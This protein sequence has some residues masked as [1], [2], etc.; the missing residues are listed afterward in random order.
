MSSP[1]LN[2]KLPISLKRPLKN[3][4]HQKSK[5][6]WVQKE[7]QPILSRGSK[8]ISVCSN[9]KILC[10]SMCGVGLGF[11]PLKALYGVTLVLS[12]PVPDHGPCSGWHGAAEH[13]TC[14]GPH[15][16]PSSTRTAQD[17]PLRLALRETH[18]QEAAIQQLGFKATFKVNSSFTCS[19]WAFWQAPDSPKMNCCTG[20][21][22]TSTALGST[23]TTFALL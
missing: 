4:F 9:Q 15:L 12:S 20:L 8:I 13:V 16:P 21:G 17:R 23:G 14:W 7:N 11:F 3:S 2:S 6:A 22:K 5:E 10:K 18:Q 19:Q 1:H